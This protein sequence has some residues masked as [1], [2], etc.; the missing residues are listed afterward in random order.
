MA[1]V[2]DTWKGMYGSEKSCSFSNKI[3]NRQ[4]RWIINSIPQS[5]TRKRWPFKGYDIKEWILKRSVIFANVQTVGHTLVACPL[6]DLQGLEWISLEVDLP[7][8]LNSVND[9]QGIFELNHYQKG[10][11]NE[12]K[13]FIKKQTCIEDEMD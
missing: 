1:L 9:L 11:R 10:L 7:T 3:T 12:L 8:F 5:Q 2:L 13:I 4:I 6:L